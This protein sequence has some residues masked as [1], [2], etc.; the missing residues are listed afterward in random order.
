M[1]LRGERESELHLYGVE[2]IG[3]VLYRQ[4]FDQDSPADYPGDLQLTVLGV[5]N[6][7][8]LGE[9]GRPEEFKV[10]ESLEQAFPGYGDVEFDYNQDVDVD[11][12]NLV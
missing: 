11:L 9:L 1:I 7:E 4:E 3:D 12:G 2:G 10:K 6:G 5:L 8:G